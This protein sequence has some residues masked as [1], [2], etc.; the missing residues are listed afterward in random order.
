MQWRKLLVSALLAGGLVGCGSSAVAVAPTATPL[1]GRITFAGSTTV[2]PLADK[3]GA[4]FKQDHP[5][6]VLDI[7]AGGSVVGIKAVH[8]GTADIGMA[9]RALTSDEAL[10]IKQDQIA[11]DVLAMVV[12][13]TNPI[14]NLT[15][16]QLRA[17]YL[18]QVTNWKDLGGPDRSIQA[19]VRDTNSGTRGA[20]DEIVLEKQAPQA[21]RQRSA[22]TAGDVAALVAADPQAI[23]YVGFGNLESSLKLLTIDDVQPTKDTARSGAYK[24]V[25][26]LLL[27]TGPLT[28]P[29]AQT[30]IDFVLS[31]A[32]QKLVE[33][34]G[35]IPVK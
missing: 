26:P 5:G 10:G 27:L 12:H 34:D 9:S 23:G 32:G 19:V 30:Y 1:M 31:T 25:R 8:D 28:Q 11:L 33:E 15:H 24:L 20:F 18:G 16:E 22:F 3:L 14:S 21:P 7:A 2:Q 4:V 13:P 17:I 29:L 35:W 6:V